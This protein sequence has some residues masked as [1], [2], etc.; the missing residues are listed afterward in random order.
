MCQNDIPEIMK[1]LAREKIRGNP[2]LMTSTNTYILEDKEIIGFFHFF[3]QWGYPVLGNFCI[4]REY[5]KARHGT[6]LKDMYFELVKT[7]G[8]TKTIVGVKK[9]YLRKLIE[10]KYDVKPYKKVEKTYYFLLGV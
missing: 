5:R 10:R 8:F 7:M 9:W 4:K 2:E 3:F 6:Y 1:M